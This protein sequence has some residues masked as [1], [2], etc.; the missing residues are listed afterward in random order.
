[1]KEIY[2]DIHN[3]EGHYQISNYGNV[4]SLKSNRLLTPQKTE[5]GYL[6]IKLQRENEQK[7][8]RVHRLVAQMF[9]SNIEDKPQ[10]NHKDGNKENNEVSNL[11]WCDN[12]YNAKHRKEVLKYKHSEETKKKISNGIKNGSQ[13]KNKI[14]KPTYYLINGVEYKTLTEASRLNGKGSKYFSKVMEKKKISP[15]RYPEWTIERITPK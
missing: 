2:I 15:T 5:K 11:E 12:N 8:F 7:T 4:K 14:Q 1:M 13:V 9:I 3:Y 6:S 10:I